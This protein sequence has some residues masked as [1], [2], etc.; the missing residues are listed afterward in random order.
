MR[1]WKL[2]ALCGL[3]LGG[4]TV[5]GCSGDDDKKGGGGGTIVFPGIP[6]AIPALPAGEIMIDVSGGAGGGANSNGGDGGNVSV[7]TG[8]GTIRGDD[9]RSLPGISTNFLTA[10]VMA[11]NL[12]TYAELAAIDPTALTENGTT[13][14]LDLVGMDFH[15]PS[16][17]TLDLGDAP[18][19]G[20][21]TVIIRAFAS[22]D[23][24]RLDGPVITTPASLTNSVSLGLESLSNT[25]T[26]ISISGTVDVSASSF[27]AT[28]GGDLV[29]SVDQGSFLLRGELLA[30]GSFGGVADDGGQGGSVSIFVD[31]GAILFGGDRV[32]ANG[33]TGNGTGDGGDGGGIGFNTGFFKRQRIEWGF[34][35]N[36][37]AS[38]GG[39][40]GG[41]GGGVFLDYNS[42]IELFLGA[43]TSGGSS[44][45]GA[46]G[47]AGRLFVRGDWV[48]GAVR[49]T[50]NGGDGTI[51]GPALLSG[52]YNI[53]VEGESVAGLAV[54]GIS[55]GGAGTGVLSGAAGRAYIYHD[56]A[57]CVNVQLTLDAMGGTSV[58]TGQ[59]GNGGEAQITGYG[60]TRNANIVAN[61]SGGNSLNLGG[62]GGDAFIVSLS[63]YGEELQATVNLTS[64]GGSGD[65]IGG[66]GGDVRL[67][68]S[69]TLAEV[70]VTINANGGDITGTP[71]SPSL[72][73]I[74][75]SVLAGTGSAFSID[76]TI[77]GSIRGGRGYSMPGGNG[78]VL[79]ISMADLGGYAIVNTVGTFDMRGGT[80]TIGNG[81]IGGLVFL[82]CGELGWFESDTL[83]LDLRG[84][85]SPT[86]DGGAGSGQAAATQDGLQGRFLG[87]AWIRG[88]TI[89]V[90]GGNGSTTSGTGVG[91]AP[92]DVSL[93]SER[94][95]INVGATILAN[96]G[97]GVGDGG[98][99]SGGEVIDISTDE[100][101]DGIAGT[102]RI[103]GTLRSRGGDSSGGNG[104]DGGYIWLNN[105]NT[106]TPIS[107]G[108][109]YVSGTIECIG[110]NTTA[111][112]AEG[113]GATGIE[114]SSDGN[115]L[116]VSG[117]V[118]TQGG[119]GEQGGSGGSIQ[120]ASHDN[121]IITI[122]G[123]V[124][125][126]GGAGND[127]GG[128]GGDI[129]IGSSSFSQ[130]ALSIVFT[131]SAVVRSQGGAGVN[132]DGGAGIIDIDAVGTAGINVTVA[133]SAVI[134]ALTGAGVS[135]PGNVLID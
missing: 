86:G 85:D 81:G 34:E 13:A 12:V 45:T 24:I 11:D 25:G 120:I 84:G 21:F 102:T 72:P 6:S 54:V 113:G 37:G 67:Q 28:D 125:A 26:A 71:T 108:D 64:N 4:L 52:I 20:I 23:V 124:E 92:G 65:S 104:G 60:V 46:G 9:G 101:G 5:G 57:W 48:R 128:T 100:D 127:D 89:N 2:A 106:G 47:T 18:T 90:S 32:V 103:T 126:I 50:A 59:G 122:S 105:A 111:A 77:A 56:G 30:R 39:G 79:T 41:N 3:V 8:S 97:N 121:T 80:S 63:A 49:A 112:S 69:E 19:A 119:S 78:G 43:T 22:G 130:P 109:I 76:L 82:E 91:G 66:A 62:N 135:V 94:H 98:G 10:G 38:S 133:G 27:G 70:D 93:Y 42:D 88:G 55:N 99:S 134:E 95:D 131:N 53:V 7:A 116:N 129:E 107:G 14:S 29:I 74:G 36:G 117:T 118:R 68:F 15:L 96:G 16:T 115:V 83:N 123:T 132:A 87:H 61:L 33:G 58:T 75:G 114:I 44:S 40:D 31:R 35:A 1:G 51:G 17:V 110:G 73:G